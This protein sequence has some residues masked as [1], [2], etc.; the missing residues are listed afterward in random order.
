MR[1]V[2]LVPL[3]GDYD[4]LKLPTVTSEGWEY[5][6]VTDKPKNNL[7]YTDIV[8]NLPFDNKRNSS[9]VVTQPHLFVQADVYAVAGAQMEAKFDFNT[10][11]L[12]QDIYLMPSGAKDM[13]E[14]A[15]RCIQ[16][17]REDPL[18]IGRQ[19]QSYF[20]EGF[21]LNS[22]VC[23]CGFTMRKHSE[24]MA[25]FGVLWF[26]ELVKHSSREQ[27]SFNY[28]YWKYNKLITYNKFVPEFWGNFIIHPH[29]TK[30]N[31]T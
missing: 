8:V 30:N 3:F 18:V 7:F 28:T 14:E 25:K 19:V 17:K 29:E 9:L 2:C 6:V 13:Y 31:L 27:L 23:S 26:A 1:K 21:P 5:F 20:D 12:V 4:K 15:I 22:G 11:D 16:Y 24:N 10:I